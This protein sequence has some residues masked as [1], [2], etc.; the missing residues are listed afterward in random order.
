MTRTIIH[1]PD[2]G[3]NN[4]LSSLKPVPSVM[5][6]SSY[7]QG[8]SSIVGVENPIKLSSNE[9]TYGPSPLAIQAYRE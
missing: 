9:S 4:S 3:E 5:N 1:R 6:L 7:V 8:Q 2:E